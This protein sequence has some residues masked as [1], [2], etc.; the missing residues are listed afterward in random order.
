MNTLMKRS[1]ISIATL[2]LVV[3]G[4]MPALAQAIQLGD[5]IRID[6]DRDRPDIQPRISSDGDRLDVEIYE[7]PRPATEIRIDDD[8]FAIEQTEPE[9]EQRLDL[10]VP[11]ERE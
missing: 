3:L 4:A 9:P 2:G 8:G 10:S 6:L 5:D 7:E 1:L 11:L